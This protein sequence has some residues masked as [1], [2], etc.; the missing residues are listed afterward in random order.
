MKRIYLLRHAESANPQGIS[1]HDRP[2]NA[3]GKCMC[4]IMN[5][6]ILQNKILPDLVLC[7]DAVRTLDTAK[8]VFAGLSVEISPNKKLYNASLGEIVREIGKVPCNINSIMVVGHNPAIQQLAAMLAMPAD[9]PLLK[10]IR[11][12]YPPC[13]F[14]AYQVD[15]N[16]WAQ[17]QL[18]SARLDVIFKTQ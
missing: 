4:K 10:E 1:D 13:T 7:S 2:L 12:E 3:N 8:A 9:K 16:K 15:I 18:E 14:V 6:Y 11:V 5:N 17:I